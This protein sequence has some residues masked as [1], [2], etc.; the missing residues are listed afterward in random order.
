MRVKKIL[1]ILTIVLFSFLLASC[2][3]IGESQTGGETPKKYS[4]NIMGDIDLLYLD[5]IK[6]KYE[7][8]EVVEIKTKI[9]FD[10]EIEIYVN[11]VQVPKTDSDGVYW[12]YKFYMPNCDSWLLAETVDGFKEQ[13]DYYK[14]IRFVNPEIKKDTNIINFDY[15]VTNVPV[16]HIFEN[17]EEYERFN[18]EVLG[19]I[20][21]H[22][23]V[24]GP[25]IEMYYIVLVVRKSNY[26]G[27]YLYHDFK[28]DLYGVVPKDVFDP[29]PE[30]MLA[31]ML[32]ED[33]FY[34]KFED[35]LLIDFVFVP[36]INISEYPDYNV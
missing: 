18:F 19:N 26:N 30:P 5:E 11:N 24:V 28:Y 9:L 1:S 2:K 15:L 6:T 35:C 7:Q 27:N 21:V 13:K 36:A 3:Q 25:N 12:L 16:Y 22:P 4:L 23:D 32:N 20:I 33:I 17:T 31:P 14:T 29:A 10:A 8:G 34:A